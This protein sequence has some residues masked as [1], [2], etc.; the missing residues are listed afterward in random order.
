MSE[1]EQEK[2]FSRFTQATPRTHVKYGGSGLGLFISKSLA[3]L[4]GG[5]IGAFSEEGVGSTFA[6]FVSTR[7]A[8]P[9]AGQRAVRAD[10]KRPALHRTLSSEDAMKSTKLN[11]LIVEDNLVNQK[12]L[13]KQLVKFGWTVH[14][15]GDGQQALAWLKSSAHWRGDRT[16][17]ERSIGADPAQPKDELDVILMDVEMPVM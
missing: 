6:F 11:V 1:D 14:V 9:P 12:V 4:Q 7:V 8:D 16:E 13:K 2:L 10:H 15:A 17:P 5:A 3:T